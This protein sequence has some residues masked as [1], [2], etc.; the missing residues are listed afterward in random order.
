MS[1]FDELT[2]CTAAARARLLD[3][4]VI[5]DCL[6][7]S[8]ATETYAAFL[9]E[10]Y[11]HVRHTVPLLMACGSRLPPRLEW[12]RGAVVDYVGEEYGHEQWILDDLRALGSDAEALVARG[13][14][15]ATELMVSYAYDT[16]QRR[17]PV[18]LFGMVFVLETTSVAIAGRAADIIGRRLRVPRKALRYLTSHGKLD[19]EHVGHLAN[20]VNRLDDADDRRAVTHTALAVYSLY[21]DI[22]RGL[23]L[24][25]RASAA[26]PAVRTR[27]ARDA[28][29]TEAV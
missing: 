13:P 1:N 9:V 25:G 4:P 22:F 28:L 29:A 7:G 18:S 3:I 24:A 12:L 26:Q 27:R 10:A 14:S 23:P 15:F 8:V 20:L 6:A 5:A 11:H 2:E 21:G 16:V 19:V 17:N